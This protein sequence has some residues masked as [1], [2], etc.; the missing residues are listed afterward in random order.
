MDYDDPQA[1]FQGCLSTPCSGPVV[2][3]DAAVEKAPRKEQAAAESARILG[4]KTNDGREFLPIVVSFD[5]A[6]PDGKIGPHRLGVK[7]AH[8]LTGMRS[9]ARRM[10]VNPCYPPG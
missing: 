2:S 3:F 8:A 1:V 10:R 9:V 7:I 6:S 4:I 5:I